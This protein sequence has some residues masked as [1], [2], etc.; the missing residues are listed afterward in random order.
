MCANEKRQEMGGNWGRGLRTKRESIVSREH[1]NGRTVYG[2]EEWRKQ[3]TWGKGREK[4][5]G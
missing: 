5:S 1:A 4:V 3:G 2:E